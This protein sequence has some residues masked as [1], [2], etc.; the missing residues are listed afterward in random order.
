MSTP[1]IMSVK[2]VTG[3]EI[4]GALLDSDE[5]TISIDNPMVVVKTVGSAWVLVP[6]MVTS[7]REMSVVDIGSQTVVS[8]KHTDQQFAESWTHQVELMENLVELEEEQGPE[9]ELPDTVH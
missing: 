7:Y 6:W 3:E 1:P 9:V 5:S 2:I 4:V 8:M